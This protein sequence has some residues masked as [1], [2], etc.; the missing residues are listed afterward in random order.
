MG[1]ISGNFPEETG[2]DFLFYK[3]VV[4][5]FQLGHST[6]IRRITHVRHGEKV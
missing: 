1:L 3:K 5:F 4:P 2:F 6:Y